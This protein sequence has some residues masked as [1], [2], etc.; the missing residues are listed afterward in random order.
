MS[1]QTGLAESPKVLSNTVL[2]T[3]KKAPDFKKIAKAVALDWKLKTDSINIS[4]KTLVFSTSTATVMVAYLDYAVPIADIKTAAA[5]NWMWRTAAEST[6]KHQGQIV[7]SVIG[8]GAKVLELYQTLTKAVSSVLENNDCLGI[9]VESQYLLI[10]KDAYLS[11]ARNMVT[12]GT[13]PLYCWIYFGI[14]DNA[15]GKCGYTY[16]LQELGIP[17]LEILNSTHTLQEVHATIYDA[18]LGIIYYNV[19]PKDGKKIITMEGSE[20]TFTRSK[21]AIL[22]GETI[23][24]DY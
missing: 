7:V 6:T 16:G 9:Y 4:D 20:L 8:N 5:L 1:H 10:S 18:A 11:A 21:S 19:P 13:L 23:K 15:G 14:Y 12:S 17:E 22:E 2:L 3:A 24:I